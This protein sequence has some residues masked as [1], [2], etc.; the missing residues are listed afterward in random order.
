M[1]LCHTINE[2]RTHKEKRVSEG[3]SE[4]S[5][6]RKESNSGAEINRSQEGREVGGGH[7]MT[8][9]LTSAF[10]L[11]KLLAAAKTNTRRNNQSEVEMS[12]KRE[13]TAFFSDSQY[14]LHL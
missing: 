6:I 3:K 1:R 13:A 7:V 5:Q 9:T 4:N 10:L 11:S 12:R 14:L 8:L 2:K